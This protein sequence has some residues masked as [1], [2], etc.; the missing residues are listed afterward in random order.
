MEAL[1]PRDVRVQKGRKRD[2]E[3][4]GVGGGLR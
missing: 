1:R 3:G 4:D 2:R